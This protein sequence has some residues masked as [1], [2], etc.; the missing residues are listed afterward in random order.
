M[1]RTQDVRRS[2][3]IW[4]AVSAVCVGGAF[5]VKIH[6]EPKKA[7]TVWPQPDGFPRF[8]HNPCTGDWAVQTQLS[9]DKTHDTIY[10]G[11]MLWEIDS[12]AE[13]HGHLINWFSEPAP[14]TPINEKWPYATFSELSVYLK[15]P[16]LIKGVDTVDFM[17]LGGE[18]TFPNKG[19]AEE[20]YQRLL[21]RRIDNYFAAKEDQRKADSTTRVRDSQILVNQ[22]RTDSIFKCKH[23][24]Q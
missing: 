24:Y 20:C 19:A 15:S 3:L 6:N 18:F 21:Q 13:Y 7:G 11:G 9:Q 17:R 23:T 12:L 8:V 4:A 2:L 16:H 1:N 14:P 22:R 10:L 5:Y